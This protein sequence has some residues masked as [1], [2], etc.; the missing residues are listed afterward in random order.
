V[1]KII[2]LFACFLFI[3]IFSSCS[4]T[5]PAVSDSDYTQTLIQLQRRIDSL[6]ARNN[7]LETRIGELIAENKRYADYYKH[8]TAAI[9]SSLV[10]AD[11]TA[12]SIEERIDRLLRIN[13]QLT[14]LVQQIAD[15]EP[16]PE[17]EEQ[18][19]GQDN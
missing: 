2:F 14:E 4:T 18:G 5:K 19:T 10:L 17:S 16:R 12:G 13:D 11:G 15:G 7:E 3:H 8:S 6:E 9:K 1:Q